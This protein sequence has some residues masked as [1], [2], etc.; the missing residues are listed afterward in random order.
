MASG[1]VA[2]GASS[3]SSLST[4]APPF[5]PHATGASAPALPGL[6]RLIDTLDRAL[7]L[8]STPREF[9]LFLAGL[10]LI[11]TGALLHVLVAAQIMAAEIQLN[12]LDQQAALIEQQNGELTFQ[13]ARESNIMELQAQAVSQGYGPAT[14]REYV[15]V[16]QPAPVVAASS[17]PAQ[18]LAPSTAVAT[19]PAP[20]PATTPAD[21]A[22]WRAWSDLLGLPAPSG[23]TQ[24][25]AGAPARPD[26][27]SALSEQ[28]ER[29]GIR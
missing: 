29:L 2:A 23:W 16:Q 1:Q 25:D 15:F 18:P 10:V 19:T 11:F 12:A 6:V 26:L 21:Q 5:D 7:R 22:P 3:L 13:I 27:F 20:S 17:V 24:A 28:L 4:L 14:Q 9:L 8:P